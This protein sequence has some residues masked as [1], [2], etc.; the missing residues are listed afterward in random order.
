MARKFLFFVASI[1]FLLVIAGTVWQLYGTQLM[2]TALK[3]RAAFAQPAPVAANAYADKALWIAR[4]DLPGNPASWLPK[5]VAPVAGETPAA[6]FFIHPTSAYATDKWNIPVDDADGQKR[7]AIFVQGQAS[8]FNAVGS[9]WAPRY[10]QATFG[11]FLTDQPESAKAIAAAY[12]DVAL[13]FDAFIAANPDKPL[14]LA[15]HSQ[16]AQHLLRLLKEKVAGTPLVKRIIAAY[17]VGWPVSITADIP[18]L[19]L[20][21]CTAASQTGCLLSWQSFGEPADP[22]QIIAAFDKTTG[23][24]GAPRKDSIMV[25]TNPLTGGAAGDAPASANLGTLKTNAE[26]SE[27]TLAAALVPARC[28]ARGFLLIGAG[29]EMGPYKLPGEN[30]HVYDFSLFW[31]NIR[32]DAQART[33]AFTGR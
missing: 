18:A 9:V 5:D 7:A 21:A 13:A 20:P 15:G 28:D 16:G 24:S 26:L 6:V 19:G 1:V 11:A 8:V 10:R 30:Y 32:A 2:Q 22:A 17:V 14:I 23:Y 33:A 31:A 3:P 29:P 4:P 27:G 25:C 12:A